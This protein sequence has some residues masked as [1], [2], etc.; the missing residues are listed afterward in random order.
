MN[1]VFRRE[2]R[3]WDDDEYWKKTYCEDGHCFIALIFR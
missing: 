3:G 2:E 1:A